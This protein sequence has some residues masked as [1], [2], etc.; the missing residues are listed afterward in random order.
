METSVVLSSVS[1]GFKRSALLKGFSI[2]QSG[3]HRTDIF[4]WYRKINLLSDDP[5]YFGDYVFHT[6]RAS[7]DKIYWS[8]IL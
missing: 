8:D 4:L 1:G 2:V 6:F 7:P 5:G 3:K